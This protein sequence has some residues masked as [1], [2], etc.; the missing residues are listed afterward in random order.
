MKT[1]NEVKKKEEALVGNSNSTKSHL[2]DL[3][4]LCLPSAWE[5]SVA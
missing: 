3:I 4:S 2:S 1:K 5:M